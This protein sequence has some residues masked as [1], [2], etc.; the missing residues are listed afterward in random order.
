MLAFNY[1]LSYKLLFSQS[2]LFA[3]KLNHHLEYGPPSTQKMQLSLSINRA[4][5]DWQFLLIAVQVWLEGL[6][7]VKFIEKLPHKSRLTCAH[8]SLYHKYLR[9][10]FGLIVCIVIHYLFA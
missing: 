2:V 10:N 5:E 8:F 7:L 1:F 6:D 3:M 4:G 9:Y